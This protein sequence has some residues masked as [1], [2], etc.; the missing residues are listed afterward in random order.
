[1]HQIT[2]LHS[3]SQSEACFYKQS[4]RTGLFHCLLKYLYTE[5]LT[6]FGFY[7][8]FLN[9]TSKYSCRGTPDSEGN[10][11]T[12]HKQAVAFCKNFR[13][14]LE[15]TEWKN[16]SNDSALLYTWPKGPIWREVSMESMCCKPADFFMWFIFTSVR[17]KHL[18]NLIYLFNTVIQTFPEKNDHH[19]DVFHE[20][21]EN[22]KIY[23]KPRPHYV[24]I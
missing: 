15:Q 16:L 7:D 19:S 1:M 10:E 2:T 17:I 13:S 4:I 8:P 3:S 11:I 24:S 23:S 18:K 22:K 5:K 12:F 9:I 20:N 21:C 14:M 6:L